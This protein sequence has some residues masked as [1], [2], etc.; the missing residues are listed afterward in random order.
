MN[1]PRRKIINRRSFGPKFDRMN[2][3][4]CGVNVVAVGDYYL[5][6]PAVWKRLG[7]SWL[8]NLCIPCLE[9]RCGHEFGGSEQIAPNLH[10]S[11]DADKSLMPPA[12]LPHHR[13][14]FSELYVTRMLSYAPRYSMLK[15]A[16]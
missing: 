9:K 12:T 13:F 8:D 5:V 1:K 10:A 16:A 4:E 11:N 3:L 14:R 7:L 6:T 2:C 15:T